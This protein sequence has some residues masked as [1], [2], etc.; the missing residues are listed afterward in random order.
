MSVTFAANVVSDR[1]QALTRALDADAVAGQL[2]LYNATDDLLVT[3]SFPK[4]SLSGVSG[5]VLTLHNPAPANVSTSGI[6]TYGHLV[7]GAGALVATVSVGATGDTAA[8]IIN[9]ATT[10]L[11]AGAEITVTAATLTEV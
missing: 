11:F 2:R 9:A 7:D 5:N 10:Q 8:F 6:A 1:L 3:L 4:P